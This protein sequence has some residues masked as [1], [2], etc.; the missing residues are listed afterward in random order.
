M[1]DSPLYAVIAIMR[2]DMGFTITRDAWHLR[3]K[4]CFPQKDK[5]EGK[6]MNKSFFLN[7]RVVDL[8]C[9]LLQN[10]L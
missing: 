3:I 8:Q 7:K 10:H 5:H 4:Y 6:R 2:M 9:C 1:W